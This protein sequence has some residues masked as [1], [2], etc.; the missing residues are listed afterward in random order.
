MEQFF[1]TIHIFGKDIAKKK[2]MLFNPCWSYYKEQL[3]FS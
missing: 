1:L 3:Y 2:K